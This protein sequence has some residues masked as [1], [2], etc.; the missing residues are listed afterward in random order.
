MKAIYKHDF[1]ESMSIV[2]KNLM[3]GLLF[4]TF[5]CKKFI[6]I[7]APLTGTNADNVF[8]NDATA[9]AVL[10]GLYTNMS[11]EQLSSTLSVIP[12]LTADEFS[13]YA[14][15]NM[16]YYLC[17]TNSLTPSLRISNFWNNYYN[18][19]FAI[20]AALE[21]LTKSSELS[22]GVQQQLL[23]EAKFLRAFF[24]FFLVNYYGDVPLALSTDYKINTSLPRSAKAIVYKQIV[25]DLKN[26]KALLNTNYVESDAVTSNL[27]TGRVRPNKA[28]ATAL[29]ARAYLFSSDFVNAEIQSSE[30]I[31]NTGLYELLK[32]N[33]VFL[34]NS[35]ESIWALQVVNLTGGVNTQEGKTFI[36]PSDGEL[37]ESYPV[38]LSERLVNSFENSDL[39]KRNWIEHIFYGGKKYNYVY[40]YKAGIGVT[41]STEYPIILRLAEQYLIRAEARIQ[42]GKTVEGIGDLNIIRRRA[43]DLTASPIDQ[44]KPL[45]L[46]LDRSEALKAV[47]D[48]RQFELF[49]E[50]G[51]RWMDLKR[52][53]RADAVLGP[54]KGS[55]WQSTDQLFPIPQYDMGTNSALR[56]HQNPGY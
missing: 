5:S 46:N 53:T 42:Q 15:N 7:P 21:G 39:R 48:E 16:D 18:R 13:L 26:A 37:N 34:K 12:G 28:A 32:L 11:K 2:I 14:V 3:I 54:L 33:E 6:T 49:T 9:T 29:L 38:Y 52:T 36:L 55:N 25:E 27:S 30:V 40:K 20:N 19:I 1:K 50:M 24:Y 23:G 43:T 17:Y 22:P 8:T 56:G 10:T 51:H 4:L 45:S 35:R 44:L 47:E 31:G 41:I